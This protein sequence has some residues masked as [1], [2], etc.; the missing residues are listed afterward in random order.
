MP[1]RSHLIDEASKLVVKCLHLL[2]LLCSCF[3]LLW[4]NSNRNGPQETLIN[5]DSSDPFASACY[6][7][8]PAKGR[9]LALSVSIASSKASIAHATHQPHGL[10]AHAT[11]HVSSIARTVSDSSASATVVIEAHAGVATSSALCSNR[12]AHS[13]T[14]ATTTTKAPN[15]RNRR[16][17][18]LSTQVL[19]TG[20]QVHGSAGEV[21]QAVLVKRLER[22]K[23][24]GV[25]EREIPLL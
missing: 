2:F 18:P 13:G 9:K 20:T 19:R 10:P 11:V 5:A 23:S 24:R 15:D 22:G 17:G 12:L 4:I 1:M 3:L 16:K 14:A 21:K 6:T 25:K 8:H 7:T